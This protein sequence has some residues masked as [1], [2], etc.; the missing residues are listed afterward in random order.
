ML[1][2]LICTFNYS[3]FF[4]LSVWRSVTLHMA[5]NSHLKH[6][7]ARIKF[8][9]FFCSFYNK[10]NTLQMH[11]KYP[12]HPYR[13]MLIID[14]ASGPYVTMYK[15]WGLFLVFIYSSIYPSKKQHYYRYINSLWWWQR[16]MRCF[17]NIWELLL[18]PHNVTTA[19]LLNSKT[20]S[21]RLHVYL[22][23]AQSKMNV[24]TIQCWGLDPRFQI[25]VVR[26]K[27]FQ[28]TAVLSYAFNCLVTFLQ[29]IPRLNAGGYV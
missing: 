26:Y 10:E 22:R 28:S 3:F 18:S 25:P 11:Y 16:H 17:M 5:K 4:P 24:Q 15:D 20:Q 23:K 6:T 29:H 19:V 2:T 7:T 13:L 14:K 9:F 27:Y 21:L 12:W 1:H 8:F